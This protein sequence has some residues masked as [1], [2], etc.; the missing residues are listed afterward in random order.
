MK[1]P[2]GNSQESP[3]ALIDALLSEHAR[4]G[5]HDDVGLLATVRARTVDV[6][7]P[8]PFPEPRAH[9]FSRADRWKAAA[10][11]AGVLA[12]IGFVVSRIETT[13]P[14]TDTLQLVMRPVSFTIGFSDEN[15][16]GNDAGLRVPPTKAAFADPSSISPVDFP[17]SA[18]ESLALTYNESPLGEAPADRYEFDQLASLMLPTTELLAR[19][20]VA[21]DRMI[22]NYDSQTLV[23]EGHVQLAHLDF[24]LTADRLEFSKRAKGEEDQFGTFVAT[25]N[26]VRVEKRTPTG[27][28]Q[29]AEGLRVSYDADGGTLTLLGGPPRLQ[30][31]GSQVVPESLD[32]AIVLLQDG[33]QVIET[34]VLGAP[35]RR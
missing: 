10:M 33:F 7:A 18:A 4:L 16:S 23:C 30:T 31:G 27:T 12:V 17:T 2:T 13:G 3:D 24:R 9:S 5:S 11:V 25:G 22:R 32:G 6:P 8:L 28:L 26:A 21:A 35:I 19:V 1:K 15:A 34:A 14:E 29:V 20:S